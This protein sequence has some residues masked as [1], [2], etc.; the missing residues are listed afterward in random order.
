M[1]DRLVSTNYENLILFHL[2]CQCRYKPI[3]VSSRCEENF[4]LTLNRTTYHFFVTIWTSHYSPSLCKSAFGILFLSKFLILQYVHPHD[5]RPVYCGVQMVIFR[6]IRGGKSEFSVVS[7]WFL[8]IL[9]SWCY[10]SFI[11]H[12]LFHLLFS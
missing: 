10:H 9:L 12:S 7:V 4:A 1:Q 2:F 6:L 8:E 5:I 3:S 11:V